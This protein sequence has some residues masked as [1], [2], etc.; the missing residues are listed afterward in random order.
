MTVPATVA[1][2]GPNA[3]TAPVTAVGVAAAATAADASHTDATADDDAREPPAS[4]SPHHAWALIP[5]VR[6]ESARK[7]QAFVSGRFRAQFDAVAVALP[8]EDC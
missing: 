3:V 6:T 5:A 2:V 4:L 7:P 8:R 1:E